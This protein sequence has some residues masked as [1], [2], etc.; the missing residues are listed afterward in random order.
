MTKKQNDAKV[1]RPAT[2]GAFVRTEAGLR[3]LAPAPAETTARAAGRVGKTDP[4]TD[5]KAED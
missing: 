2:G 4:K 5:P 3:P 1:P